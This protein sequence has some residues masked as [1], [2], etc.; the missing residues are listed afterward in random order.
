MRFETP[1]SPSNK[2]KIIWGTLI[3]GRS[4]EVFAHER[5]SICRDHD[6]C[7]LLLMGLYLL[8]TVSLLWAFAEEPEQAISILCHV[9]P[10]C[11][12]DL[13]L[14]NEF[15]T[16]TKTLTKSCHRLTRCLFSIVN[17]IP[18]FGF[19]GETS[20]RLDGTLG[21]TRSVLAVPDTGAERNVMSL[22]YAVDHG[23]RLKTE[24][25][26]CGY[27]QFA[28]GSYDK[29]V[30]QVETSW[31][32]ASGERISVTF[33]VLEYCCSDVII[34]EQILTDHN[35]FVEHATSIILAEISDDDGSYGLA[36]FDYMNSWQR[37]YKR[38]VDKAASKRV[39]GPLNASV[40][41]N[42]YIQE[43]HRRNLWN[44]EYDFGINASE[45]EQQLEL[46]RRERYK[47]D[48]AAMSAQP[49]PAEPSGASAGRP[50]SKRRIP[51][52]PSLPTS[53]SP[54]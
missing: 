20:Q 52:V 39:E 42:D 41:D 4:F 28:D 24:R 19:L 44:Y 54:W 3:L 25:S 2:Q 13:V 36:P 1:T 45:I 11:A 50:P 9:L 26:H 30:G 32:F 16:A 5:L 46:V 51:V 23:F 12:Y 6:P 31:T 17:N 48:R 49:N 8:G 35:V 47:S 38:I 18:H 14:G 29:T 40:L 21:E 33:E 53:Q 43:Q 34:G 10:R 37:A 7:I 27:L 15:L 22:Q